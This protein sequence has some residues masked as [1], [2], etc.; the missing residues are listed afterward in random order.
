MMGSILEGLLLARALQSVDKAYQARAA[1]KDNK[2]G[3]PLALPT[4]TLNSLLDVAIE[5]GWIKKDRGEFGHALRQSRNIVHPWAHVTSG[6]D[7]DEG[8]A[9]TSWS[10]LVS[11]VDDLIASV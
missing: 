10:V 5:L 11:A 8:T 1:P 7:L 4:W 2:T 6:A 9:K 3:K